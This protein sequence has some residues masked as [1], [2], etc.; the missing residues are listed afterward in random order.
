MKLSVVKRIAD[1]EKKTS[2]KKRAYPTL[3][4]ICYDYE[5]DCWRV[6]ENYDEVEDD[7]TLHFSHYRDYII[8]PKCN[9]QIMLDLLS[10]PDEDAANFYS[11][12]SLE[13]L[14]LVGKNSGASIEYGGEDPENPMNSIFNITEHKPRPQGA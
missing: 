10:C 4:I 11:F 1:L 7:K 3:I 9:A 12:N 13:I 14:S 8:E 6:Q 2:K 5:K